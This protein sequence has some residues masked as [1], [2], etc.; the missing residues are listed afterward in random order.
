MGI[1]GKWVVKDKVD[2][3]YEDHFERRD[4]EEVVIVF[5]ARTKK[6]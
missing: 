3:G 5:V 6:N 1:D 4:G 2:S